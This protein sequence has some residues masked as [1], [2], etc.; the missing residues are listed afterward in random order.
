MKTLVVEIDLENIEDRHVD[1]LASHVLNSAIRSLNPVVV[2][3]GHAY[4]Y[5]DGGKTSEILAEDV[6]HRHRYARLGDPEE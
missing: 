5:V 3:G 2:A 6:P 1:A 4:R